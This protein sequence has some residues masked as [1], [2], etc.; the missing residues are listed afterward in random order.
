MIEKHKGENMTPFCY[1]KNKDEYHVQ[2]WCETSSA[3]VGASYCTGGMFK[4]QGE[5]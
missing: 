5:E 3:N 2:V 1:D 4:V